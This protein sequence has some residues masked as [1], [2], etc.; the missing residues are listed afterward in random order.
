MT[1]EDMNDTKVINGSSITTSRGTNGGLLLSLMS[2][3]IVDVDVLFP[4]TTDLPG[5]YSVVV[6]ATSGNE[7]LTIPL[8]SNISEYE[9]IYNQAWMYSSFTYILCNFYLYSFLIYI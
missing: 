7:T 6:T 4:G 5:M 8:L 1:N 3:I 2:V 9:N